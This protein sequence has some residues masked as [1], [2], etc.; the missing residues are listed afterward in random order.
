MHFV[1]SDSFTQTLNLFK[2]YC[3]ETHFA[4][5][6]FTQ[7][8]NLF[9]IF[10]GVQVVSLSSPLPLPPILLEVLVVKLRVVPLV[11]SKLLPV[12]LSATAIKVYLVD[13]FNPVNLKLIFP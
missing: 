11:I 13:G 4:S 1:A 7:T 12:P 10:G 3:G 8:L 5:S 2:I 9:K 6:G